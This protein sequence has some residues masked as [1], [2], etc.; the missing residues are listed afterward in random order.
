[1]QEIEKQIITSILSR[2]RKLDAPAYASPTTKK[3]RTKRLSN[4]NDS[5]YIQGF[6]WTLGISRIIAGLRARRI[7]NTR[8]GE[9]VL[10]EHLNYGGEGEIR[11]HG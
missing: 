5:S 6:W 11:T 10:S 8:S 4:L 3:L 2:Y 1:M 7:S 9:R